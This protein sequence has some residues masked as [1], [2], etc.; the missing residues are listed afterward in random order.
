MIVQDM[1]YQELIRID[2]SMATPV[3]QQIANGLIKIIREGMIGP[4]Q[5]IPSSRQMAE[6]LQVH[7]KT[8]VAAYDELMVQDWVT[9]ISRKGMIVSEHLPE[10][11]PRHFDGKKVEGR[12]Y[13]DNAPPFYTRIR[14]TEGPAPAMTAAGYSIIINDGFPDARIAPVDNLMR[15]YRSMLKKSYAQ[16]LFMYSDA[17]GSLN[18]RTEIARFLSHTRSLN[19]DAAN[20]MVTRGAQTAIFIAARMI[21]K[22][23]DLVIVGE[24]NYPFANQ[25]FEHLGATLIRIPVDEHGIDVDAIEQVCRS[26]RPKLLYI[27]PHHHHPTTVILS[28][29]RR[30]KLLQ[31]IRKYSIPVIE[32]DYDY[33]IHY[34]KSPI[35]PLASAD[36]NGLVLYIGSI[37]KSFASAIRVGY[38][39]GTADFIY[40]ASGLREMIELRGDVLMEEAL[41]I[42][43]K[44]G[45][46]QKHIQKAVKIYHER[47]DLFC[48]LLQQELGSMLDVTTPTGGMSA[49]VRFKRKYPLPAVA[50]KVAREGILMSDGLFYNTG[51][52]P[53]NALRMGF[54]SLNPDE[55]ATVVSILKKAL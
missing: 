14:D 33:D 9:T 48:G 6:I 4:G 19:I 23:G 11:T 41:A 27:I 38:L 24:P 40:H 51:N 50:R 13:K 45:D 16:G 25:V 54:A 2:K 39:V 52:V 20:T 26:R 32:D 37:T 7:R 21:I 5:K 55:I 18:L 42:L 49:W 43:Y 10:L 30:M 28:A 22:P 8:I 15:Y 53:Y 12:N 35:L 44:N 1:Q 36:H 29:E 47:R 34:N 31:L 3:Y 46:M 17:A